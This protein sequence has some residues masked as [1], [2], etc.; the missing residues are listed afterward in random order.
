MYL[1][2]IFASQAQCY[3]KIWYVNHSGNEP[4]LEVLISYHRPFMAIT[5]DRECCMLPPVEGAMLMR[6]SETYR[7]KAL[8][9]E[10]LARDAA[11]FDIKSAWSDNDRSFRHCDGR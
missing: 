7:S 5:G 8:I 3:L 11:N 1:N 2:G 6:V 4:Q 10:K 9:C